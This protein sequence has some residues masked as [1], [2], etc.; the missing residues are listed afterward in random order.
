DEIL[1]LSCDSDEV[2]AAV[3]EGFIRSLSELLL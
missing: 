2:I 1:S 3:L